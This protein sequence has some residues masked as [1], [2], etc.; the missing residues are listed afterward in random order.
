MHNSGSPRQAEQKASTTS[1]TA[2]RIFGL[3]ELYATARTNPRRMG[4]FH[5]FLLW[6]WSTKLRMDSR[7]IVQAV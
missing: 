4:D 7:D 6:L 1:S 3:A 2:T 5:V